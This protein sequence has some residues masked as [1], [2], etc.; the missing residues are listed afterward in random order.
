MNRTMWMIPLALVAAMAI[1]QDRVAPERIAQPPRQDP[2]GIKYAPLM[3]NVK[4][5]FENGMIVRRF[6]LDTAGFSRLRVAVWAGLNKNPGKEAK[7]HLTVRHM[8]NADKA[9]MMVE[10]MERQPTL[11]NNHWYNFSAECFLVGP[12]TEVQL[13]LSRS[14]ADEATLWL[15]VAL[16]P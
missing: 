12:K 7:A 13:Q 5:K 11:E 1:G 8:M 10:L 2:A 15:D 9:S 14:E 3:R 6:E 4:A 16:V